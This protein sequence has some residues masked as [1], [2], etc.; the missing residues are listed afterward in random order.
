MSVQGSGAA[1]IQPRPVILAWSGGKDCLMALQRL[2]ADPGWRVHALLCT[3]NRRH[4]RV[5][6]HG[7]RDDVLR[8]QVQALGE[9]L[10]ES[11]MDWPASNEDYE[12]A[13]LGTLEMARA[14]GPALAH[15]AFGD[16]FLAD[17]RR[18]RE[19][20]LADA[21]WRC[22][23]PLWGHSTGTL[24]GDFVTK[25]HRAVLTCVDTTQLDA[26]FSGR[27]F[28]DGLL[29]ELPANVDPCG[30]NGEFHTLAISGPAFHSPLAVVRGAT[31][32]RDDRF[33][34]TDFELA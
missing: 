20:L 27:A 18:W 8:A 7:I 13:F 22:V 16:I 10:I 29:R 3:V 25:G 28:D 21:G 17:V 11:E 14:T 23:F 9:T 12:R 32:L 15:V 2:R 6:M 30:E 24:A 34:Y 1:P 26:G 19:S 33:S 31:V 5:A 4:R